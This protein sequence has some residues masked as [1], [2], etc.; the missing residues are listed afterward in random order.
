VVDPARCA[1]EAIVVATQKGGRPP[2]RALHVELGVFVGSES[3]DNFTDTL[4]M[5]GYQPKLGASAGAAVTV[6]RQLDRRLWLGGFASL[7]GTP[8]WRLDTE[9][10]PLEFTWTTL[11]IGA[12]VRGVQPVATRGLLGRFALYAQLG[13][14]L[15]VARTQFVDQDAERTDQWFLGWAMTAGTGLRIDPLFGLGLSLGYQFDH[16]PVIENLIGETHA[17]GGHRASLGLSYSY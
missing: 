1:T 8:A 7:G 5:F 13:A 12:V 9:R 14:G 16:A 10:A 11:G 17:S 2:L 3:E 15:G 4:R 6:L